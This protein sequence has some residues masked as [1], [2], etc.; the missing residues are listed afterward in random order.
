MI[1]VRDG[2][3]LGLDPIKLFRVGYFDP[4]TAV[5][6]VQTLYGLDRSLTDRLYV[7]VLLRKVS[8]VPE[9]VRRDEKYSEV[10]LESYTPLDEA[11][12]TGE[13][14]ELKGS[15]LVNLGEAHSITLVGAVFLTL[16]AA[17]EKRRETVLG[18]VD[19]AVL[20]YTPA[21]SAALSLLTRPLRTRVTVVASQY[22]TDSLLNVG[23][24]TLLLYHDPDVQFLVY[25][26]NGI[27]MGPVRKYVSKG[28]GALILVSPESVDVI[29]G[30]LPEDVL[31]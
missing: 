19:G 26:S 15:V 11:L 16:A 10:I 27:P 3:P 14:H 6:I 24:P 4:Y 25:E 31:Q 22:A 8:S 2:S 17:F 29:F 12:Y 9:A 21:G 18:L 5:S 13:L 20:A 7:D 23:G 30:E 1:E 28:D